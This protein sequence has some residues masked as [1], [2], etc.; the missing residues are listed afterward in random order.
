MI[1][2]LRRSSM[3]LTPAQGI[4]ER[5][6]GLLAEFDLDSASAQALSSFHPWEKPNMPDTWS[7]G[8]IVGASGSGKSLLLSTFGTPAVPHWDDDPIIES[9]DSLDALMAA[10]LNDV[11]AWLRPYATLSTG[12]QFRA[13]LAA[14]MA[15]GAVVDEYTSVVSRTVARSASVSIR[16]YID[17][18]QLTRLVFATCHHDVEEWLQPDWVIDTDEGV[19]RDRPRTTRRWLHTIVSQPDAEMRLF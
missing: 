11:P 5:A 16:R 4:S 3:P 1:T 2:P 12:Q 8:L 9:F 17:T 6:L 7:V 13:D 18:R 10:G 15:D 14:Q 19:M